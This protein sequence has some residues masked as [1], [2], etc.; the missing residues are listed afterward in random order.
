VLKVASFTGGI[1][2]PSARYRVRQL[3][4]FLQPEGIT[5]KE[6]ISKRGTYPPPQKYLRPFWGVSSLVDRVPAI[7]SSYHYDLTW[8]QREFLSTMETLESFTSTPRILD[9]D[10][11]IWMNS[12]RPYAA[13]LSVKCD[14]IICG[15]DYLAN[16]FSRWNKNIV[17]IPT[18]VD[19]NK[20]VPSV[21]PLEPI[22]GWMGTNSNFKY[23][24]QIEKAL[25]TVLML[26]PKARLRIISD[27]IPQFTLLNSAQVEYLRWTPENEVASIQEMGI[28]L[29]P[30]EDSA[31]EKGKCSYKMLLYMACGI[32]VVV[33]PV[34]MNE[35]ILALGNVGKGA[36]TIP[37]WEKALCEL[38]A[39]MTAAKA[40]GR[41][42]RQIACQYFSL[43]VLAPK[44]ADVFRK[45]AGKNIYESF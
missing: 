18:A 23:L 32:P 4:P 38:L 33:S 39:D 25:K 3:I 27:Q 41:S 30:L 17:I 29:M 40:M 22:I 11:A 19:T 1:N 12:A 20:F 44:L 8:L 35:Q 28:G 14:L 6:F 7:L 24:Y 2:V 21:S 5:V 31:W 45:V 15:N 37:E 43:E 36:S 13:K 42:G 10:D 9:V 34:G 26:Y 16:Y